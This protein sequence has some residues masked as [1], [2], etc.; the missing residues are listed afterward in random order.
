MKKSYWIAGL[1][2]I[3]L[4]IAIP[5]ALFW[6]RAVLPSDDPWD[7][8]P[9]HLIHTDYHDIIQGPFDSP[10]AVTENCLECH[11]DSADEVMH[12]THWTWESEPITVPW[13][14]DELITI[15]KKNQINNF[16]IWIEGNWQKCTSCHTGYGWSDASFDFSE[17][18][19]VD[20]LACHASTS[21]YAKGDDGYPAEGVDC[22]GRGECRQPDA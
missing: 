16:C 6:P 11:P 3:A 8:L 22:G 9:T 5:L 19:N 1:L 18:S 15:G 4:L 21:T 7:Y 12:T 10:Q 20:C 14:S 13:R 17:S 2:G